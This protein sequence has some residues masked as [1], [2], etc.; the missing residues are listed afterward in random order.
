MHQSE[1]NSGNSYTLAVETK[2]VSLERLPEISGDICSI[3]NGTCVKVAMAQLGVK[4]IALPSSSPL[5]MIHGKLKRVENIGVYPH[6]K[7]RRW[8]EE[9]VAGKSG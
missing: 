1:S 8:Y 5:R 4:Q 6:S 7:P 3:R 2:P 9:V